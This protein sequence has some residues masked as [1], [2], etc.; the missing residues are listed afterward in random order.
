MQNAEGEV[1]F[2][3]AEVSTWFHQGDEPLRVIALN[4]MLARA[5]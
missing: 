4:G 3:P 2:D 1:P 5:E